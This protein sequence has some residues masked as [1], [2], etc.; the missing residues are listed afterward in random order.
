[1]LVGLVL[2]TAAAIGWI[3]YGHG[4]VTAEVLSRQILEQ[5]S[6][7]VE[8]RVR[9]LLDRAA[10]QAELTR[11]LIEGGALPIDDQHTI[12]R[13]F[14]EALATERELSYLSLGLEDDGAYVHA[15]RHREGVMSV[16]FAR[17]GEDGELAIEDYDVGDDGE[18]T[19][20][21]TEE[22][23]RGYDPRGRPYYQAALAAGEDTW[24]ETYVFVG[25][26]AELDVPGV[27]RAAPIRAP[28][29]E[30]LGVASADFELLALSRYLERL[31][32]GGDGYAFLL[33]YRE[34]G[35][36]RVIAHP[37]PELIVPRG[38]TEPT[39]A[40]AIDDPAARALAAHAP[41]RLDDLADTDVLPVELDVGDAPSFASFKRMGVPDLNWGIAVVLPQRDVMAPVFASR[42]A[43][44]KASLLAFLAAI[45]IAVWLASRMAHSLK[46]LAQETESVGRMQFEPKPP[47]ASALTEI[48]RLG[49]SLEEMKTGLRSFQKFVPDE[50]VHA[51]LRSGEEATLG[52]DRRQVTIY[53]SD[54]VGFTPMAE[55]LPTDEL[56]ALL[57]EY[58]GAMTREIHAE[59]GT[60]DKYIG[61]GIMGFWNA[62]E[63]LGDHAARAVSTA[64]SSQRV[65]AGLRE[66][67]LARG[68]PQV[69]ARIG[70]HTGEVV[71][72]N[73]GSENRFDYTIIGDAV[74]L[75]ARLEV[76][77]D[78]YGTEILVSEDTR[79]AIGDA[80]VARAI[81]KVSVRGKTH[82]CR[83]YEV[84]GE[85]GAIAADDLA[86]VDAYEAALERYFARDFAG[87]AEAWEA[88]LARWPHDRAAAVMTARARGLAADPP[89][90]DWDG[91][92]RFTHK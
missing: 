24:T 18:L 59:R 22:E 40:D 45:A 32:V 5:T 29:G 52:S 78:L 10:G 3:S 16:R 57:G 27:T 91:T 38:A 47:I 37:R 86:R 4:R 34:D 80:F 33:E 15:Y 49:T 62:P 41:A 75:A 69:D 21:H 30:I 89:P 28:D 7:R 76:L 68:W 9:H 53:F 85:A 81:D 23:R 17:P 79:R 20:R 35:S 88:L 92:H 63:P 48:D 11:R 55:S 71:V 72:G 54:V 25:E 14:T 42:D 2:A 60:I 19:L 43:T 77:N 1:M 39:P 58:L 74:N 90:K 12:A 51:I 44:L 84:L 46:A 13:H 56:A 66:R 6:H 73:F 8:L 61:D 31:D 36:V 67:W 50:L 83:I 87:A 70:I 26:D 82:G 64:L 65:L